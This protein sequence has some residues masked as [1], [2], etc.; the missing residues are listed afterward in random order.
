[1]RYPNDHHEVIP[2]CG[3]SVSAM[4]AV[5]LRAGL[6]TVHAQDTRFGQFGV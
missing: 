1:V 5:T 4:Y 6:A 2:E 3:V